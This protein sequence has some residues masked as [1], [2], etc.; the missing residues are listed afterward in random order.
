M[1]SGEAQAALPAALGRAQRA[2]EKCNKARTAYH[3]AREAARD[4]LATARAQRRRALIEKL[5]DQQEL[6]RVGAEEL[7]GFDADTRRLGGREVEQP[8]PELLGS[9]L[10]ESLLDLRRRQND[11]PAG[12]TAST[13][14]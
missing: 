13:M 14:S 4:R 12:A 10:Q 7:A 5:F 2:D 9:R 3:E 11:L 1:T 6:A 8:F